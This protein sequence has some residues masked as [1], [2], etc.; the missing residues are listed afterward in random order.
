MGEQGNAVREL[1]TA[2]AD[3]AEI[4]AA[5]KMLLQLKLEYKEI[6]GV[7]FGPPKKEKAPKREQKKNEKNR[8]RPRKS[9]QQSKTTLKSQNK[10][11]GTTV[12][13]TP[14]NG[15]KEIFVVSE[16]SPLP[17]PAKQF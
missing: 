12:L 4:D 10:N 7:D 3:K 13:L 11:M 6:A 5:V 14:R 9:L 15:S 1:K 8:L 16:T 2:K 17:K